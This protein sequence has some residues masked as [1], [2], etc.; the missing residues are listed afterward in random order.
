[1]HS[2][3][4]AN[5]TC[6][7]FEDGRMKCWG[8]NVFGQLGLGDTTDR[9]ASPGQ[10]GDDLPFV[11]VGTGRTVREVITQ[12]YSTCALLDN[13]RVKCWGLND[14]GQLG[15]GDTI[16]RGGM[17]GQMGDNLPYVELL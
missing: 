4:D 8:Q 3:S 13:F 12:I 6:A 1:M 5:H 10:M 11:D 15:L 17:P 16:N 9:G 2:G 7:I 14:Q